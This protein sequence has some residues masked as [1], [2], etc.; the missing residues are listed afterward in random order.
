MFA[1][2]QGIVILP[3]YESSKNCTRDLLALVEQRLPS[4]TGA[5]M[6]I[7]TNSPKNRKASVTSGSGAV[8]PDDFAHSLNYA[9]C[10][11]WHA[12][13][14]WPDFANNM[15]KYLVSDVQMEQI[16]PAQGWQT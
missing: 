14:A 10:G 16:E 6:Y 5:D 15:T 4:P 13:Q 12:N 11:L 2:K 8:R 7:V 3:E 1:L 9:C